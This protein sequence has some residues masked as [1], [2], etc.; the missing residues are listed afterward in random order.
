M[1]ATT[2]QTIRITRLL[3]GSAD[4]GYSSPPGGGVV[5][6][7]CS[8]YARR[9]GRWEA[10]GA[11]ESGSNQGYFRADYSYGPWV[12]RGDTPEEAIASMVRRADDGYRDAMRR[13]GHDAA[14]EADGQTFATLAA[15]E[16]DRI[17]A[18][19]G[20]GELSESTTVR[21]GPKR[22][23]GADVDTRMDLRR[24]AVASLRRAAKPADT[25]LVKVSD[26]RLLREMARRGLTG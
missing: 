16:A 1:T 11:Y 18:V 15:L 3:A 20:R 14:L 10:E 2:T 21:I 23:F 24:R 17:D 12:G 22:Y 25:A 7:Q 8:L 19:I 5:E 4:A 13:A 9:D 26:E 6:A